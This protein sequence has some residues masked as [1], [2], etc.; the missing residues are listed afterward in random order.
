MRYQTMRSAGA[1]ED[2]AISGA[3]DTVLF[4]LTA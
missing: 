3:A 1:L 4:D 2:D